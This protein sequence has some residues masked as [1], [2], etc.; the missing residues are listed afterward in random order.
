LDYGASQHMS[1]LK[2]LFRNY[3]IIANP[4]TIY[5]RDNTIHQAI[6]IGSIFL[7]LQSNQPLLINEI[8][9]VPNLAKNLIFIFQIIQT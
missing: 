6:G 7:Q 8:L 9:H 4:K 1:A 5:L 2:N 3:S